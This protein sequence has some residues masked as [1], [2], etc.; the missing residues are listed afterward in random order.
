MRALTESEIFD[1]Y[2]RETSVTHLRAALELPP[3]PI[4][5]DPNLISPLTVGIEIEENWRQAL[6]ELGEKWAGKKPMSLRYLLERPAFTREYREADEA[7]R[8][9]LSRISASIPASNDSYHEFSFHPAKNLNYTVAEIDAL[10]EAGLLRNGEHYAL[11]MTVAGFVQDYDAYTFLTAQELSGAST[12]KRIIGAIDARQGSWSQKG[13]G[14]IKT[15]TPGELLGSDTRGHE[16]RSLCVTSRDQLVTTLGN[17][18]RLATRYTGTT[19][20]WRE[21]RSE[22]MD[23]LRSANLPLAPWSNPKI[24]PGIW[25][26]YAALMDDGVTLKID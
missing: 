4:E 26:R 21:V 14:G 6:P 12:S 2:A 17:A 1:D 22:T 23:I 16:F 13:L 15:R 8:S 10:F 3:R 9:K 20:Q 11:H 7:M 19:A 18:A 5:Q 25:T 24:T